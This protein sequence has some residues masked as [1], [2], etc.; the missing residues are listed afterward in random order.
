MKADIST[1]DLPVHVPLDLALT[2]GA[3]KRQPSN[4]LYPIVD[5]ELR[6]VMS[7]GAANRLIGVRQPSPHALTCRALDGGLDPD[8]SAA[9][10]RMARRLLSLDVDLSPAR[11]LLAREPILGPLAERLSGLR[12]PR[13]LNLWETFFQVIPFQQVSLAAAV[14]TVNR[15]AL[16]LGPRLSVGGVEYVGVPALDSMLAASDAELRAC[17]LS[18]A[19]AAALRGS[20]ERLRAGALRE[21]D[22]DALPDDEAALALRALPG[23]G[24]WSAQL[25]LLRGMGRLRIFPQGDSG[26]SKGLRE[27][28]SAAADPDSAATEA[29]RR[30]SEWRGYVYFMLLGRRLMAT[31]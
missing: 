18:A 3:L 27:A 9:I 15:L 10:E 2:A 6:M 26:A 16:A 8:L 28:F 4:I 23:I 24:P 5:G 20:A 14:A 7:L 21:A 29:L 13:F 17:G 25:V 12:P 11:A 22:L 19:K 31:E 1:F 30:L